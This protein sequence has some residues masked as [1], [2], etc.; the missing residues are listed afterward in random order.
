MKQLSLFLL[1]AFFLFA[2]VKQEFDAPPEEPKSS[3]LTA[4][5][6]IKELKA[7]HK[8]QGA[9]DKITDEKWIV[10]GVV[11]ADDQSGNYYKTIVIQDATAG[12][13]IRLDATSLYNEFPVG[14]KVFIK[15]K[16][17]TISDYNGQIQLG[18][19]TFKNNSGFDQLAGIEQ[20]LI[21]TYVFKGA[22]NQ[23]ITPREVKI[24][25]LTSDM[26]STLVTLKDVE[27]A[28]PTVTYADGVK[29]LTQNRTIVDCDISTVALRTSGYANFANDKVP[30]GKGTLTG[31][32]SVFGTTNQFF[33]RDPSDAKMTDTRCNG[34]GGGT[35]GKVIPVGDLIASFKAGQTTVP[36]G[37]AIKGTVITDKDGKNINGQNLV[38]QGD[39][40][41][42]IIVRLSSPHSF[43]LG[44]I[45]DVNVGGGALS[46]FSGSLQVAGASVNATRTG[47]KPLTPKKMTLA[48][49][50]TNFDNLE[51][52]LVQ[53][54]NAT[55]ATTTKYGGNIKLTDASGGSATLFTFSTTNLTATFANDPLPSNVINVVGVV[56]KYV[57][58]NGTPVLQIQ[59]RNASDVTKGT[60]GST[61]GGGGTGN[62][63]LKTIGDIRNL[64]T[65]T[66]TKAPANSFVKGIVIS[67]KANAN[68]NAQNLILQGADGKGIVVRFAGTGGHSFLLG[69]EIEVIVSDQEISE[70]N[71]SLQLNAIPVANA[72]KTGT[73]T[74]VAKEISL[75][76]FIANFES[77][78]STLVSI[79][80][81]T[82]PVAAKYDNGSAGIVLTDGAESVILFTAKTATFAN[83]VPPVG[84]K[85][86]T[87]IA[88]QFKAAAS[89]TNGYQL[90]IRNESDIK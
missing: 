42:G 87:A 1:S 33:I 85:I 31:I 29:K 58:T 88:G 7:F 59:M 9:F 69:D 80:N 53:I 72:K 45:L 74:V 66:K 26:M 56:T 18:G 11:V 83:A 67:D 2:C 8:I 77:Y 5:I 17:L 75:S 30:Q 38:L 70:F 57:P 46:L 61:G 37:T 52:T 22:L 90:Q 55:A 6:S 35:G 84:A 62:E 10:E 50:N 81:L 78:E 20:L 65:G 3:D 39:D 63:V 73:G 40:N 68:I 86:V 4:T 71:A 36:V 19:G 13:D 41:R 15:C 44:D 49:F 47:N 76:Q 82:F 25:E 48:E 89:T 79:S 43:A 21:P 23:K 51:S 32:F 28:D 14:R 27:F 64:Y 12:I 34:G 54:D 60:G 24:G 16:D